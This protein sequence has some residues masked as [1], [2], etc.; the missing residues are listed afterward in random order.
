MIARPDPI[1]FSPNCLEPQQVISGLGHGMGSIERPLQ[2]QHPLLFS[3]GQD[4]TKGVVDGERPL[5]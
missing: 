5:T 1:F 2:E 4:L 3:R